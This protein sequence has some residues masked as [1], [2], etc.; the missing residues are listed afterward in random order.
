[1]KI[2]NVSEPNIS[3]IAPPSFCKT[4]MHKLLFIP[5]LSSLQTPYS[6]LHY[7]NLKRGIYPIFNRYSTTKINPLWYYV[8]YLIAIKIFFYFIY[9]TLRSPFNKMMTCSRLFLVLLAFI[10]SSNIAFVSSGNISYEILSLLE[11]VYTEPITDQRLKNFPEEKIISAVG[12]NEKYL[13]SLENTVH[14]VE[15]FKKQV[16][17]IIDEETAKSRAMRERQNAELEW[18]LND[19]IDAVL[20]GL[21]FV[22]TGLSSFNQNEKRKRRNAKDKYTNKKH[23]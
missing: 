6:V 13:L 1:M 23:W 11:Q 7:R 3:E 22:D 19:V 16:Y 15:K 4:S 20:K 10:L 18:S 9:K 17:L 5:L 12:V 8:I 14:N 21:G 2:R